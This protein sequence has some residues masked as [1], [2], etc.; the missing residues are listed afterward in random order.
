[1]MDSVSPPPIGRYAAAKRVLD[2]QPS[3]S[4]AIK[5]A[6]ECAAAAA[7]AATPSAATSAAPQKKK[8]MVIEDVGDA[9]DR[10]A[11]RPPPPPPPTT[12]TTSRPSAEKPAPSRRIMIEEESDSDDDESNSSNSNSAAGVAVAAK[13]REAATA[14]TTSVAANGNDAQQHQPRPR[15]VVIEEDDSSDDE[16][17]GT[18][19]PTTK[20]TN[21]SN[22]P[23]HSTVW[24]NDDGGGASSST[25]TTA[26]A[27]KTQPPPL[28]A[29]LPIPTAAAATAS[30]EPRSLPAPPEVTRHKDAGNEA[31]K[32][33]QYAAAAE[34]YTHGLESLGAL[35]V[36]SAATNEVQATLLSNRAAC[37]IKNGACRAALDDC[38]A[39]I[40]LETSVSPK[41]HLRRAAAYEAT[42]RYAEAFG[43]FRCFLRVFPESAAAQAGVNRCTEA[44][45][46]EHGADWR[47]A[48]PEAQQRPDQP[49]V[50]VAPA[51]V[52]TTVPADAPTPDASA[53]AHEE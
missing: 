51:V 20:P 36:T 6:K 37:H 11:A 38:D 28:I 1:M 9:D 12:T 8:R 7:A 41:L 34:H 42:E 48:V 40:A 16:D 50:S 10:A 25:P 22:F 30:C 5:I 45:R 2:V 49:A 15:K 26:A 31:F 35:C 19:A 52:T 18:A 32:A 43:D 24:R 44:L 29:E 23:Q 4:E 53:V 46:R 17:G 14:V 47:K 13:Q 3:H 33:G 27:V 39:G 21:S